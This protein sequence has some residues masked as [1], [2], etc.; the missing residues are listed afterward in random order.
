MKRKQPQPSSRTRR[1]I[2]DLLKYQ[3]QDAQTLAA[4]LDISP[5]AVRQHLY[6]LQEENLV[7]FEEQPRPI[8]RPAKLWQLT[9]AADSF[10]PDAHAELTV[11][12][13]QSMQ[14]AF[15]AAG[16]EKILAVRSR[17]QIQAYRARMPSGAT[18]RRRLKALARARTEEGYMAEV[19]LERDGSLLFIENHCPI[20]TAATACTG[21]C[22]S[23]LEVFGAVLGEGVEVQRTEHIVEGSRRC[24]YRVSEA[25]S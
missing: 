14:E 6:A 10:F 24:V 22:A 11:G 23:E 21:L 3:P 25:S 18:L 4:R 19:K 7:T 12:L 15:G 5:M 17:Q 20:C 1:T 2:M 8:G 16:M 13:I 9:S